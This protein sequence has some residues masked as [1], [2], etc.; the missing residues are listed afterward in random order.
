MS[1][2]TT[3]T[4]CHPL[5]WLLVASVLVVGVATGAS[6][7]KSA[8]EFDI[9]IERDTRPRTLGVAYLSVAHTVTV[10]D[11][12]TGQAP[13]QSY[14]VFGQATNRQGEKSTSFAC[15]H[16]NDV[17]S[18]VPAGVY[19][20]T[21]IVDHG[22]AWDFVAVVSEERS[23][24]NQ[25][26]VPLAQASVAFQI[27][28]GVAVESDVPGTE[29]SANVIDVVVL[30]GHGAVAAGW[31]G[32]VALLSLLALPGARRFL[33]TAGCHR[34]ERRLDLI[35]K[36]TWV[37]TGLVLGSGT[38]LTFTQT[39]YDAPFSTTDIDNVFALPY[40]KPYFLA[41]GLKIA[42]Y[43]LMVAATVPLLRGARRRM[44]SSISVPA[45]VSPPLDR[46]IA[47]APAGGAVATAVRPAPARVVERS[48][49][50]APLG[51]TV[52]LAGGVGI[53]ACVTILKYLHE[54][55]E[56]ARGLL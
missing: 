27:G 5:R 42:L 2:T 12:A 54:L 23:D 15:G 38:Y 36:A 22:G 19:D 8:P 35:V 49:A 4:S 48:S 52:V 39:A 34:L 30:F 53:A 51:A 45:A 25:T 9:R 14:V 1:A 44:L 11:L 56:S 16:T 55:I 47:A 13:D 7:A 18:R 6:A 31:F 40:G 20:C 50:R 41:L 24:P 33:S 32:C 29:I 37:T 21:V 28:T 10:R 3:P 43:L 46:D 26:P 17:D